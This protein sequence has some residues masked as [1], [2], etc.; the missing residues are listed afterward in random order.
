MIATRHLRE[1]AGLVTD[2]EG[3]CWGGFWA[4]MSLPTTSTPV[5]IPR[6][7]TA[8]LQKLKVLQLCAGDSNEELLDHLH[9]KEL[10]GCIVGVWPCWALAEGQMPWCHCWGCQRNFVPFLLTLPILGRSTSFFSSSILFLINWSLSTQSI[11]TKSH[12]YYFSLFLFPVWYV[13]R[14]QCKNVLKVRNRFNR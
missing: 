13:F 2:K 10:Q 3:L 11:L 8:I 6:P 9:W 7:D 5:N 4:R 1:D 12:S 14:F